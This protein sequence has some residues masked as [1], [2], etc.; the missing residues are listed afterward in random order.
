[1]AFSEYNILSVR[2]RIGI[3]TNRKLVSVP[4]IGSMYLEYQIP[5]STDE[6]DERRVI[7]ELYTHRAIAHLTNFIFH[8][9][10]QKSVKLS[11]IF[12]LNDVCINYS[13]YQKCK[14]DTRQTP[15]Y[16]CD[17]NGFIKQFIVLE[18][19]VSPKGNGEGS[20]AVRAFLNEFAGI[21]IILQAGFLF[22]GDYEKFAKDNDF[23]MVEH[24]T[25]FYKKLG[26]ID[27]NDTIGTYEDSVIMLN[28]N[29]ASGESIDKLIKNVPVLQNNNKS[30]V[31]SM[32]LF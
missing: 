28:L 20:K 2:D 4:N 9:I 27:V 21:P 16:I 12:I 1:M 8:E 29:G 17:I 19:I 10:P 31:K 11:G 14:L 30:T 22:S 15:F 6:K 13:Y 23:S 32:D 24:L 26:F 25:E 18:S 3:L 5:N 7:S